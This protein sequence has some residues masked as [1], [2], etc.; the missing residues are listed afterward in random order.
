[1]TPTSAQIQSEPLPLWV[2]IAAAVG[3]AAGLVLILVI[4]VCCQ[5]RQNKSKTK[6]KGAGTNGTVVVHNP[7]HYDETEH[8]LPDM[9]MMSLSSAK[10]NRFS[11]VERPTF[12]FNQDEIRAASVNR[13]QE[14]LDTPDLNHYAIIS[15]NKITYSPTPSIDNNQDNNINNNNTNSQEPTYAVVQKVRKSTSE[16]DFKPFLR[17]KVSIQ[18]PPD[19]IIPARG[20]ADNISVSTD[21]TDVA[22]Y[23]SEPNITQLAKLGDDDESKLQYHR[24]R[25]MFSKID[26]PANLRPG[27]AWR[28]ARSKRESKGFAPASHGVPVGTLQQ[29]LRWRNF[30]YNSNGDVTNTGPEGESSLENSFSSSR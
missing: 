1:M 22:A 13:P 20:A 3:G 4:C 24:V 17:K 9:A 6:Q 23:Q 19:E 11:N 5:R 28:A 7:D 2:I 26:N 16:K 18:D 14:E 29:S 8:G 10:N 21:N 27:V 12:T 25:S 30:D 15:D